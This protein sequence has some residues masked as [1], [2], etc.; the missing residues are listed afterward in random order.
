MYIV[1]V[2]FVIKETQMDAFMPAMLKQ[3]KDSLS[4]EP[5]C[6]YFDVAISEDNP[7][8]VFLY[9]IYTSK[10]DFDAHLQ[11]SHFHSFS[12]TVEEM[13]EEKHVECFLKR[14]S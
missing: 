11:S 4:L 9:E 1:T 10:A 14:V 7:N 12:K 13:V 5:Q 6:T 3:A 8:V 2:K